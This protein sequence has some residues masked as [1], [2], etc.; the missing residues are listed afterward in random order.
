MSLQ[1]SD[2]HVVA[3]YSNHRRY[4]VR[5]RL[6]KLWLQHMLDSG[7]TLTVVQHTLGDRAHDL[8]PDK[9]PN[10]KHVNL[11][12]LRGGPEQEIWLQHAL[13]NVGF[14]RLPEDAKFVAWQ[15]TDLFYIRDDW[16]LETLHML[17]HHRIG[18]TWTHS[19]DLDPNGNVIAN[20]WDN[21]IDRSFCAAWHRGDVE[22][23][24]TRAMLGAGS[25]TD[26][27]RHTGFGWAIRR[28]ILRGLGRLIDWL[29]AGSGDYHMALGF[30][31]QLRA[32][33]AKALRE[34]WDKKYSAAYYRKLLEWADRCDEWVRQDIGVVDGTILHSWHGSKKN[35]YYGAREEILT[36][37]H[38]DPDRDIGYDVHGVPM[39]VGDNRALR[40]GL[41]RYGR[42]RQED[43][44]DID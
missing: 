14:S 28:D 19:V 27:R 23:L 36:E 29:V 6:L 12:S 8:D 38:F 1:S 24:T 18:Q 11:V 22:P 39:L 21:L 37:A 44:V 16:P 3:G 13:Y 9:D 41:R 43:S 32:L 42:M 7:V 25:T 31:G 17:Q 34:G 35:R 5:P 26:W 4:Q 2:L 33:V 40:D 10:L 30:C 20:E 15:D